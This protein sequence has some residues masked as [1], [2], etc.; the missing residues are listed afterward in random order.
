MK[1]LFIT[2]KFPPD[3][4]GTATM[5]ER[6]LTALCESGHQV[7]VLTTQQYPGCAPAGARFVS[8]R[9]IPLLYVPSLARHAWMQ[10]R[11]HNF[12]RILINDLPS[13]KAAAPFFSKLMLRKTILIVHGSEPENVYLAPSWA[14][15]ATFFRHFYERLLT[16]S[17]SIIA[18]SSF[19]K[20]K[21]VRHAQ[22]SCISDKVRVCRMVNT[23]DIRRHDVRTDQRCASP[24]AE[25]YVVL[26]VA[27]LVEKKGF[28]RMLRIMSAVISKD[29]RVHWNIVGAG[30]Y[31]PQL[32]RRIS[33]LGLQQ[34]VTLLGEVTDRHTLSRCYRDAH[35]FLLLSDFEEGLGLVYLEAAA[36]G[37]PSIAND[38]SGER[39]AVDHGRSGF[40][41]RSDQEAIDIIL[42]RRAER[43]RGADSIYE[44]AARFDVRKLPECILSC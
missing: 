5:A 29:K 14:T 18:F 28:E 19:M 16:Q 25:P 41:V 2:Y 6:M 17:R 37:L 26:T 44:F 3:V 13:A 31:E 38:K 10:D 27:R 34:Y 8:V 7:T 40:L 23:F 1:L 22:A 9:R 21:L 20:E 12:D 24:A 42:E 4:G 15:R 11:K 30:P 33:E 39:E 35:A 36:H 32:K 43:L